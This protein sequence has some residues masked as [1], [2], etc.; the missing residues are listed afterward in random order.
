[1]NRAWVWGVFFAVAGCATSDPGRYGYKYVLTNHGYSL[2]PNPPPAPP[3]PPPAPAP[4]AKVDPCAPGES[5]TPDQCPDLDDDGDGIPNGSDQCPLEKGIAELQGCA[6]KDADGDGVPD[7]LDKCP[8]EPG[9]A[10]F[11]GCPP[12]KAA[13]LEAGRISIMEA[14]FFDTGKATLQERS[15]GVLDDVATV[16]QA[17]PEVQK[18]VVGGHTDN[19]GS[20]KTNRKLSRDRAEAVKAYLVG[21]GIE[22]A[23]LEAA[24]FGP[25]KPIASNKT[26][27]GRE[28]NRRVEFTI[29]Q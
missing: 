10:E 19:T 7:H 14:V 29:P 3:A 12:P 17:H 15:S 20:A 5:H 2:V 4:V 18:V 9:T 11:Q 21:K 28:K 22:A 26:K 6:P 8:S 1:M 24:G 25:D 13:K 27:A 16:L 23:R